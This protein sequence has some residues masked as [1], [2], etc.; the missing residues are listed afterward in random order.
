MYLKTNYFYLPSDKYVCHFIFWVYLIVHVVFRRKLLQDK[1][2][3][4]LVYIRII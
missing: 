1:E 2:S 4:S 3:T